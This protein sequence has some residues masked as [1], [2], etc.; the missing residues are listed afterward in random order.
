[1]V[2]KNEFTEHLSSATNTMRGVGDRVLDCVGVQAG[3]EVIK[4]LHFLLGLKTVRNHVLS[5]DLLHQQP[6]THTNR[7][8]SFRKK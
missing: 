4:T 8:G 5:E 6:T 3:V 7:E 2:L 1:M